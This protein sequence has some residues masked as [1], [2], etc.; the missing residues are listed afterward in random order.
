LDIRPGEARR[1]RLDG[2]P[3][4]IQ[5]QAPDVQAGPVL[6]FGAT[7]VRHHFGK[8]ASQALL[9]GVEL[10]C[11]HVARVRRPECRINYY[12]T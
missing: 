8:E 5:E 7:H 12:L 9:G 3:L 1:H 10:S 11:I 4:P 6:A 2:L